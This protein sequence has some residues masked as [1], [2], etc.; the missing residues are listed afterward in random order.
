MSRS[1]RR[2]GKIDRI[3]D[4]YPNMLISGQ[5]FHINESGIG[6]SGCYSD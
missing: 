4:D 3:R 5:R 1:N 2:V 6:S